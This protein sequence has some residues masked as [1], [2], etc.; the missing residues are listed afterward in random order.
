MIRVLT[1]IGRT[2]RA[3]RAKNWA[4]VLRRLSTVPR[5]AHIE[6][7]PGDYAVAAIVRIFYAE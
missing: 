7:S 3:E 6:V 4:P 1:F 5:S 2:R